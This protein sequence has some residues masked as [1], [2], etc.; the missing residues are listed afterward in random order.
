[1]K[2][3][4]IGICVLVAFSVLAHGAVEP[5]SE[6]VLEIGAAVLFVW[7]GL[8]F[9][10]GGVTVL[11]WNWLLGPIAGLWAFAVAQYFLRLS[12]VPFLT[13]IEIV[14]FTALGILL[15]L[16]V[17]AYETLEHRQGFVWF[18]LVFG[19]AVS[20]FAILQY[21]TFNGKLYWLRELRNG[22]IPFGP[23]VNRNH[24]SGL[25]ELIVPTGLS[26]IMLRAEERDRM[27]LLAILTL[28]PIGALFLAASRGGIASFFSEVSLVVVLVF[29][30]RRGRNQLVAG[31]VVL[32]LAGVLVVW[33]GAGRALDRFA[34]YRQLEVTE[35]RR[36]EMTKDTLRIFFDHPVVGTGLG[37][38]VKA[39]PRYETL[40]DGKIVDHSHNDY[41]EA[42]AETGLIGGAL[43]AAFLIL[44]FCFAWARLTEAKN[45]LD[46]ALHIGALAA[47]CGLLIHSLVDFNLHIPSNALLFLLEAALATSR[48][49]SNRQTSPFSKHTENDPLVIIR[50]PA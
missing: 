14:K 13:E 11:R 45:T 30:R 2:A 18:T 8:L 37:T 43:C 16:A 50:E 21:F 32:M 24:F 28:L 44:L 41:A 7:W 9:A 25:I 12:A 26:V 1:M 10:V 33:L 4:R 22:G 40:Y 47:C 42:L 39:F 36:T 27:P 5:W 3:I 34:S 46:L 23:Y 15:F 35:S 19:F 31:A 29:S 17:Q 48:T 6:A 49:P 38:L 20:V